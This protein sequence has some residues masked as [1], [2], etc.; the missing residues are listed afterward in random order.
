MATES[1]VDLHRAHEVLHDHV[2]DLVAVFGP[3]HVLRSLNRAGRRMLRIDAPG[4]LPALRID[5]FAAA[6]ERDRIDDLVRSVSNR[7]PWSGPFTMRSAVTGEFPTRSTLIAVPLTEGEGIGWIAKDTTTDRDVI[8]SLRE[9]AFY[10]P[11]TGLR[12]GPSS[13]TVSTCCCG[14]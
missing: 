2:S 1:D 14:G 8:K 13:S 9:R 10:D 3:D 11:L 7:T 5:D 6:A 12:T 4:P